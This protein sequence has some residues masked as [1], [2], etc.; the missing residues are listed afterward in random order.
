MDIDVSKYFKPNLSKARRRSKSEVQHE[1]F[2]INEI[3]RK[4]GHGKKY[5]IQTYGCQANEADGET[6]AGILKMMSFSPA[7]NENEAS[8]K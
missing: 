3:H 7:A 5:W 6:M 8:I 4:L 1:N 2:E